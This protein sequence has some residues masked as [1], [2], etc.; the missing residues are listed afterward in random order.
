MGNKDK[1]YIE[2]IRIIAEA[3][4]RCGNKTKLEK[5][6]NELIEKEDYETCEGIK[7]ALEN[8]C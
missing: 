1:K 8:E 7:R 4:I 3:D 2:K 5:K 6:M